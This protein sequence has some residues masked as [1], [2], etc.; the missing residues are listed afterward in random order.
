MRLLLD[1]SQ[2][3]LRLGLYEGESCLIFVHR[4]S[5]KAEI[6]PELLDE[7]LKSVGRELN[8]IREVIVHKG[9]GS[10]TGLRTVMT[11]AQSLCMS[12]KRVLKAIGS[13]HA[14]ALGAGDQVL[15]LQR[16]NPEAFFACLVRDTSDLGSAE[17]WMLNQHDLEN[18]A[19]ELWICDP[20]QIDA[21]IL[22]SKRYISLVD[23]EAKWFDQV[24]AIADQIQSI[25]P[26]DLKVLYVQQPSAERNLRKP[27]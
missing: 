25:A 6:F 1:A 26:R 24:N 16:A 17:N 22:K 11:F 23:V 9:P 2:R 13:L 5:A 19:N 27:H 21:T 10:F 20:L 3:D 12:G 14:L 15:V 18:Y 8:H 4:P 7:A